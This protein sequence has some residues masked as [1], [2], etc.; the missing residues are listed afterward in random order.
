MKARKAEREKARMLRE[1]GL[2][3]REIAALVGASLSSVSV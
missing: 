3:L 1:R 2:A